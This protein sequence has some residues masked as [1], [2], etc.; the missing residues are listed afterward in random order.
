MPDRNALNVEAAHM[1]DGPC[2]YCRVPTE[3]LSANPGRWP[4]FFS[5]AD[6]PGVAK[7][8]HMAC[9]QGRMELGEQLRAAWDKLR[10]LG[11]GYRENLA[12]KFHA[13]FDHSAYVFEM[14]VDRQVEIGM[15]CAAGDDE[16]VSI[17]CSEA[18]RHGDLLAEQLQAVQRAIAWIEALPENP[19]IEMACTA[20]RDED[21]P[22]FDRCP[23]CAE[24]W[25][26][27]Q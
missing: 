9:V 11:V 4:L 7:P 14:H 12:G 10:E 18:S 2:Y 6:A 17:A 27:E 8:H 5:H 25:N 24:R 21:I 13:K 23:P 3:S 22:P 19:C 26:A 16:Y 20:A 1:N 15:R